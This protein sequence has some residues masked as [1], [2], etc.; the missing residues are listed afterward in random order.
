MSKERVN[1]RLERLEQSRRR[2]PC[3]VCGRVV[4]NKTQPMERVVEVILTVREG[5]P[6]PPL[7]SPCPGCGRQPMC[8][9]VVETV[10]T[11]RA[12]LEP[13]DSPEENGALLDIDLPDEPPG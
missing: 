8:A 13:L 6:E 2:Q 10:V 12:E 1:R 4:T 5:E 7:P 3:R 11:S 9:V